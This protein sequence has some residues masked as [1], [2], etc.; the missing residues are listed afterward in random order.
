[1]PQPKRPITAEEKA[2]A[3]AQLVDLNREEVAATL[4]QFNY[5]E[6][7]PAKEVIEIA[8]TLTVNDIYKVWGAVSNALDHH[9][10]DNQD[11]LEELESECA[12]LV[13]SAWDKEME[14]S[15]RAERQQNI[16]GRYHEPTPQPA[17][18]SIGFM[19]KRIAGSLEF[20]ALAILILA[21]VQCS[22]DGSKDTV[23]VAAVGIPV[24]DET[25]L[26]QSI[27]TSIDNL[28]KRSE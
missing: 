5:V 3:S 19:L 16:T 27:E 4:A 28:L 9:S 22:S 18:D 21:I 1:M 8:T 15:D 13:T 23:K 7:Q 24:L 12:E 17:P 11:K 10:S 6:L 2:R 25:A 20:V 26:I 14:L